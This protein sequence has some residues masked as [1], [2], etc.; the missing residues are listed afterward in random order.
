MKLTDEFKFL[1]IE[2]IR[3][4]NYEELP[5]TEQYFY[6]VNLIDSENTPVRF[7]SFN[8]ELNNKLTQEI[9]NGNVKGLQDCLVEFELKYTNNNWN[10]QL[11]N[12]EF[13]Y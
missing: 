5:A 11:I 13:Q 2:S 6:V 8:S 9:Q 4:K 12:I 3:R 10:V 7:F 1:K